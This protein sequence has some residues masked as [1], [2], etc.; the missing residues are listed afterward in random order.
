MM[1]SII[2][3]AGIAAFGAVGAIASPLTDKYSSFFVFGDSLSDNGNLFAAT[4]GNVP[5]SP[6]YFD[7]RFSDGPVWNEGILQDFTAAGEVSANFA[8]GGATA[9]TNGD[10]I[11]DLSLQLG[12]FGASVPKEALGDRP[13]ASLWFGANDILDAIAGNLDAVQAAKAAADA[14]GAGVRVLAGLGITDFAIWNLPEIGLTPRYQLFQTGSAGLASEASKAFNAQLDIVLAG[15]RDDDDLQAA[16]I[17]VNEVNTYGLFRDVLK[18]PAAFGFLDTTTPCILLGGASCDGL[19]YFDDIHPTAA[20]HAVL[21][22][23]FAAAIPLPASGVLLAFG[24]GLLALRRRA[25]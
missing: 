9:V 17:N 21:A 2:L 3:A 10:P 19:L 18:T 8:F 14:I 4:G 16:G 15:L 5:A 13:L 25:A 23:T 22:D 24:L 6:P 20:A 1:R 7:G 12:I 11:P